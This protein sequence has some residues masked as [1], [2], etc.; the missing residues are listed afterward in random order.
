M[1]TIKA[2]EFLI[3]TT[4]RLPERRETADGLRS[5]GVKGFGLA[6]KEREYYS[7]KTQTFLN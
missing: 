5:A 2:W 7:P 4:P 6:R 3:K 1:F